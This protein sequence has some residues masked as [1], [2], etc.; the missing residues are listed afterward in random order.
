VRKFRV[1]SP[2]TYV[3]ADFASREAQVYRLAAEGDGPPQIR[4]EKTTGEGEEPLAREL[5]A[6]LAGVRSRVSPV[7]GEAGRRALALALRVLDAM[8][9]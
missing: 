3:S 6:F 4:V 7:S 9:A 5:A 1:F 8:A 2:R